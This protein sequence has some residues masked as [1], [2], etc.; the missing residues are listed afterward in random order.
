M[1]ERRGGG[2][3]GWQTLRTGRRRRACAV[4]DGQAT[5]RGSARRGTGRRGASAGE[6][7]GAREVGRDGRE[8]RGDRSPAPLRVIAGAS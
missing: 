2:R 3:N 7:E 1:R 4:E 5:T 6:S 8:E